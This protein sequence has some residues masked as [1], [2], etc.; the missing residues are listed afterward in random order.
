MADFFKFQEHR[1]SYL[2]PVLQGKNTQTTYIQ[3]TEAKGSKDSGPDREE[4]QEKTE[5]IGKILP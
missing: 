2:P 5:E 3:Q 4:N 1:R